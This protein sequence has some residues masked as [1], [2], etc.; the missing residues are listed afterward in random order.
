M[1]LVEVFAILRDPLLDHDI[2]GV[3]VSL[4]PPMTRRKSIAG[5]LADLAAW[6][7]GVLIFK[8]LIWILIHYIFRHLVRWMLKL[9]LCVDL[10]GWLPA[11][12]SDRLVLLEHLV[13]ALD[14]LLVLHNVPL[15]RSR[16]VAAG[17][18]MALVIHILWHMY[19]IKQ[20]K[21][22]NISKIS[23]I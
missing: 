18:N 16:T 12:D 21:S 14:M 2:L 4:R 3:S 22:V 13:V 1:L 23:A 8:V 7:F 17:C 10:L 11:L 6:E 5:L 20:R 15:R 9:L 19:I